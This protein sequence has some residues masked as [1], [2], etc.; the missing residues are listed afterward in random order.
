MLMKKMFLW[1]RSIEIIS[2]I[3]PIDSFN[4][5]RWF[6]DINQISDLITF[7]LEPKLIVFYLS[8]KYFVEII[9][10]STINLN[11]FIKMCIFCSN[12]NFIQQNWNFFTTECQLFEWKFE[13]FLKNRNFSPSTSELFESKFT[14]RQ[15]KFAL[16]N[17]KIESFTFYHQKSCQKPSTIVMVRQLQHE[18]SKNRSILLEKPRSRF[19]FSP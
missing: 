6:L 19:K 2:C 3:S 13:F 9:E 12:L 16:H 17:S 7:S 14:F 4:D 11:W 18:F 15:F 10:F 5:K 8:N 1:V